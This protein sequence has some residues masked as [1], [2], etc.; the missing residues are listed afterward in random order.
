MKEP[1][2]YIIYGVLGT[3]LRIIIMLFLNILVFLTVFADFLSFVNLEFLGLP[4]VSG[5]TAIFI[6]APIINAYQSVIDLVIPYFIVFGLN[7]DT[8]FEIW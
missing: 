4:N 3:I 6:G 1:R 2:N 7:L 8:K 5:W